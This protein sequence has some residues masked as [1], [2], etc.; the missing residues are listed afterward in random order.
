MASKPIS[1]ADIGKYWE[2][3][4]A[5]SRDGKR[6]TGDQAYGMLKNSGL[7]EDQLAKIWDLAD[8]DK[9]GDLDFE[10]FCVAMRLIFDLVNG[11]LKAVPTKLPAFLVPESKAHLVTASDALSND[12]PQFERME[13]FEDDTVG[14]KDGFDWYMSPG[15]KS[16][17]EGIYLANAGDHGQIQFSALDGLY[18]SI[19][20]PDTDIRFAWNLVNPSSS[21]SIGKDQALVF[22]HILNGRHEGYRIPRTVPASLRA[23]FQKNQINYDLDKVKDTG[24]G[25]GSGR[26]DMNTIS[27]KK[28]AFGES[29]L[30]RLGVGGRGNF[31][32]SGTDFSSTKDK[33]WEEVRLKRELA[34]LETKIAEAEA[35]AEKRRNRDKYGSSGSKAALVKRELEQML[36]YKRRTLRDL[37][38]GGGSAKGGA[39]LKSVREDLE[40][41]RMQ[42]DAVEQHLR[43]RE[44]VL[45]GVLDEIEEE[46]GK[47]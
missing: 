41:V 18:D 26:R 24:R 43:E 20:V 14:L 25:L 1:E 15:D 34:D 37:E 17:Y 3:F 7:N 10:E 40:M 35:A 33:D 45:Q 31:K 4:S 16:K 36:D 44:G 39:D 11:E 38:D 28:E 23:T 46:K 6:I 12:P 42:V 2:I 47:R 32:H 9:D 19:N 5:H 22:L 27:G 21:P 30:T 13:D 8:V 29:Y